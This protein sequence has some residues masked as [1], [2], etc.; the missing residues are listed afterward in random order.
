MAPF[1]PFLTEAIYRNLAT[2]KRSD[3]GASVHL[4]RY[5]EVLPDRIDRDLELS[6]RL[7]REAVVMGRALRS[8]FTIKTRQ[9]LAEC[10]I[11]MRDE[12]K[13]SL[14]RQMEALVREELNVK[15]VSF[16][17]DE[18]HVVAISAR[19]NFK[20]LG[21]ALGPRMKDAAAII[22]KFSAADIHKLEQGETIEVTGIA[23]H[24]EDIEIRRTKHANIEVEAGAEM[25]VALDTTLTP[26]LY[27]EG[28]AREFVNRIQNLRKASGFEVSDR[29]TLR[30][31]T[32][33]PELS[34]STSQFEGY[35]KAETLTMDLSYGAIQDNMY[36]ERIEIDGFSA[37]IGVAKV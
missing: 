8:K 26:E 22:E 18:E 28:L 34:D 21:K 12:A 33:S 2:G 19:A 31:N 11:I 3:A 16:D 24:F 13:L 37:E 35:I 5:P 1:L 6:M 27:R 36:R 7:V 29:I 15:K 20:K 23:L 9:P 32:G 10:T 14:V 4:E 25:I 17:T 30:C